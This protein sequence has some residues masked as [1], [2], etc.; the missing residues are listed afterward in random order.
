MSRNA[1]W[2]KHKN[3]N[4]EKSPQREEIE[5]TEEQK[6]DRKGQKSSDF[7]FLFVLIFDARCRLRPENSTKERGH[8]VIHTRV[9]LRKCCNKK[10]IIESMKTPKTNLPRI[11][12]KK[13]NGPKKTEEAE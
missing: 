8:L 10:E 9:A 12:N 7:C 5:K 3:K 4:N 13:L 11:K 6:K 2:E 1:G